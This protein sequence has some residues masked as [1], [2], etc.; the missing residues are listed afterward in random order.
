M[1]SQDNDCC[2]PAPVTNDESDALLESSKSNVRY[3]IKTN[4]PPRH[5]AVA[6]LDPSSTANSSSDGPLNFSSNILL[7]YRLNEMRHM[8]GVNFILAILCLVFCGINIA[9]IVVNYVNSFNLEDPPISEKFFHL[10]EFWGTF[11]FAV[12]EC[13]SLTSTPKSILNIYDNPLTL[14]LV[15]FFNI[16]AA[17]LP[18]ILMTMNYEYFEIMSHE[19]EYFNEITMSFVD[20]VLLWSLCRDKENEGGKGRSW[21]MTAIACIVA[22]VQLAVYN[23]MGRTEDGDMKGE[24][25][26]HYLEFTF[27]IISS[28][29]AF[30]FCMDNMFVCGKEIGEI[31]YGTHEYCNICVDSKEEFSGKYLK[32]ASLSIYGSV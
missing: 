28:L 6:A 7:V 19:I 27:G 20:V 10:L 2:T 21:R 12:V 30:W 11:F 14:R 17:S 9:L 15:L 1:T 16:V 22:M 25:P 13:I 4:P 18:A 23:G 3:Q 26:A 32:K 5:T 24:V 31:L 8:E 29:I